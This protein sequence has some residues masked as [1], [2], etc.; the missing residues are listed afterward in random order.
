MVIKPSP[1]NKRGEKIGILSPS[2][3]IKDKELKNGIDLIRKEGFSVEL[4]KNIFS[5]YR[6]SYMAGSPEKRA[7]D[8]NSFFLRK[9]IKAIICVRGGYGSMRILE[10][11][12]YELIRKNPKIFVGYSDVTAI[13]SAILERSNL[14]TFHGPMIK[15]LISLDPMYL[16]QFWDMLRGKYR[17]EIRLEDAYTVVPGK[18][19]GIL[20]GGNL[21]T[22][23]HL[24]GTQFLPSLR[25]IVLFLEDVNEPYYKIDRMITHLR[26]SGFFE[27]VRGLILGIFKGCGKMDIIEKIVLDIISELRIPILSRFH[28]G[29]LEKNTIL[30]IGIKVE[31]DSEK[32]SIRFLEKPFR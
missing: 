18:A 14:L 1:I 3:P 17:E 16:R 27:N 20:F 19:K 9:D 5:S 28:I 12:D 29:H 24:I 26:L 4:S 2:S 15:D 10:Y 31:L 8:I 11:I 7:E 6:L 22:I 21:S 25:N 32:R 13:L 30:P 23:S